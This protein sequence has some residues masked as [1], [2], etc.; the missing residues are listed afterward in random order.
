MYKSINDLINSVEKLQEVE[1]VT[2]VLKLLEQ[3]GLKQASVAS[4]WTRGFIAEA[5][6]SDIDIAYVGDVHY[7]KAQIILK[8]IIRSLGYENKN[9]DVDGI[10]NVSMAYK[11]V[12]T[13]EKNYLIYYVDSIDTVYLRA[14]G[15]LIDPTG[16]GFKD[17][18]NKILRMNDFTKN[19]YNYPNKD[20]VYLCLEGCRRIAK[21][22]WRQSS[23][24][25]S[26]IKSGV[27]LWNT[28]SSIEKGYFL[29]KKLK[30]KYNPAEYG[31]AQKIYSQFG[32]EFV[33]DNI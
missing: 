20:I 6:P 8:D 19:G 1:E 32:W 16:Y 33:F 29:T 4:G 7:E 10:W 25:I 18:L 2:Q 5:K 26:L 30:A 3:A 24:S 12:D 11:D 15:K 14:D 23:E 13:V 9:W 31:S 27:P 21:F 28:L 17:A 22:G